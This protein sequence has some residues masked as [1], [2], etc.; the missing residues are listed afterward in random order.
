MMSASI[1][2]MHFEVEGEEGG[3]EDQEGGKGLKGMAELD[4][5]KR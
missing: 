5:Q 4:C 2:R 1:I 3:M